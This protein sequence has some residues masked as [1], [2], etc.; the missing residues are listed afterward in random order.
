M[1]HLVVMRTTISDVPIFS[2]AYASS[3]CSIYYFL[4]TTGNTHPSHHLYWSQFEDE[5]GYIRWR[6]TPRP[7]FYI[8]IYEFLPLIDH[9]KK[10]NQN[11]LN[12]D[13]L[14][15]T[16]NFWF[17]LLTNVVDMCVVGFNCPYLNSI[18]ISATKIQEFNVRSF[19]I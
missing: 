12:L 15:P 6:D 19:I 5:F 3:K 16:K 2:C 17:R 14:W 8:F 1:G 9:H 11:I 4:S 7:N 13:K 10:Q 18:K